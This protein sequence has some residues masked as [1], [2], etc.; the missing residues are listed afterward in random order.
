MERDFEFNPTL[1][2]N[3]DIGGFLVSK[4]HGCTM[5]KTYLV[6]ERIS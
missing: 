3:C 2:E 6:H 1:S 5:R 4:F